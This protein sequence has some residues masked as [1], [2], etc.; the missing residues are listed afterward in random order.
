MRKNGGEY[1]KSIVT[2]LALLDISSEGILDSNSPFSIVNIKLKKKKNS[3]QFVDHLLLHCK[4]ARDIRWLLFFFFG[5]CWVMPKIVAVIK[6]FF[7]L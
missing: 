2:Q 7:F 4:I 3:W 5:V 6:L 1:V